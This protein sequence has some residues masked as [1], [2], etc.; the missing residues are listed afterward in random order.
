VRWSHR[1]Q[2]TTHVRPPPNDFGK[3][4]SVARMYK[5]N[6]RLETVGA[7][8][9]A[10]PALQTLPATCIGNR[11]GTVEKEGRVGQVRGAK[12][13]A[14]ERKRGVDLVND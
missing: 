6:M 12:K 13:P 10:E 8:G 7:S 11:H 14:V 4:A 9:D 1:C 3:T 5:S 2:S